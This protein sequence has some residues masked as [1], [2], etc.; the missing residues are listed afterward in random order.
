LYEWYHVMSI[1][2]IVVNVIMTIFVNII[3]VY[4]TMCL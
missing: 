1:T 2:I 3:W 4:Q